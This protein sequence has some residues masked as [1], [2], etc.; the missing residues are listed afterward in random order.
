MKSGKKL[1]G[2]SNREVERVEM[3]PVRP[4]RIEREH[5]HPPQ[6]TGSG[7]IA[8]G[9]LKGFWLIILSIIA[10]FVGLAILGGIIV[11]LE[12]SAAERE[13]A[14]KESKEAEERAF[15]LTREAR[16]GKWQSFYE[17]VNWFDKIGIQNEETWD[18]VEKIR[19]KYD[20]NYPLNLKSNNRFF[21]AWMEERERKREEKKKRDAIEAKK[22]AEAQ[23]RVSKRMEDRGFIWIEG[24]GFMPKEEL[25]PEV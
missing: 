3:H 5:P 12:Q 9:I 13:Q 7:D 15:R 23:S 16:N 21:Y 18:L 2:D 22:K 24:H 25:D 11:G 1:L 19:V 6:K 17:L 4:V 14:T 20:W 10:L 8:V